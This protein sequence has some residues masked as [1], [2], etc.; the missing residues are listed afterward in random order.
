MVYSGSA[1]SGGKLDARSFHRRDLLGRGLCA[2]GAIGLATGVRAESTGTT[3]AKPTVA[4]QPVAQPADGRPTSKGKLKQSVARW[5]FE[6]HWTLEKTCQVARQLGCSSVELVPPESWGVLKEHGLICALASSHGFEK[7]MNNPAYQG[8]CIAK[9]R[10]SIDA[11]AAAGFPNAITFTGFR[12]GVADDAGLVNCVKGYKQIVG[13]AEKNKVNLCLEMLNSRV[14]E[15]MKGH[16]GYQG[17]HTDYVMQII[18]QVG[19]PRLKLLFDV[20]HVQ[21]M[22]GDLIARLRECR[23]YIGHVH[24]AGCPGRGE[25]DD[26]QEINYPAVMRALVDVGYG[27]YVGQEFVPTGD[28]LSSLRQAVEICTV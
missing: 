4:E 14:S 26:S 27:G 10:A 8:D 25:I 12:E 1:G 19:S 15:E 7:G 3:G 16:P 28:P 23:D 17:D 18:K 6:K 11:C 9:M 2:L 22:D 13:Y 21:I 20:Y 5:C 24:V